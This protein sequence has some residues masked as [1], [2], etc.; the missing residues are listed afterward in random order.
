VAVAIV[1][2]IGLL[3]FLIVGNRSLRL[4]PSWAVTRLTDDQGRRP[5]LLKRSPDAVILRANSGVMPSSPF[6]KRRTVSR[7]LS[8]HSAHP[9]GN[10]PT[11]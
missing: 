7:N 4:K 10:R 6:Q 9:G 2:A 11:W 1:F 8:F 3:M 5:R